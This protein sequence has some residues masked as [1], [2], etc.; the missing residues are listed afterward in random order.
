[1]NNKNLEMSY[2]LDEVVHMNTDIKTCKKLRTKYLNDLLAYAKSNTL[3][4]SRVQSCK[5]SLFPVITKQTILDNYQEFIVDADKI[6]YQQGVVHI[7]TT[8]GSTGVPFKIHQ[9]TRSRVRRV[10]SLKYGNKL[11]SFTEGEPLA[12]IRALG[13]H[14]DNITS[15]IIHN[16]D[17]NITY[18]DNA[19]LSDENIR[20]IINEFNSRKVKII[21]GYMTSLDI[22]TSY[23]VNNNLKFESYP[24]FISVGEIMLKSLRD[25]VVNDLACQ[26]I[27]QYGNEENGIIGQS[28]INSSGAEIVLNRASLI[29]EI[30]KLNEDTP[31]ES[32]EIGRVVVTDLFNYAQPMIRY[33]IGDTA[34][35]GNMKDGELLSIVDLCGRK[36]DLIRTTSGKIIDM[37]NSMPNEI[38]LSKTIKQWQ[39]IQETETRYTLI[40][41]VKEIIDIDLEVLKEKL[42]VLIGVDSQINII[43][44]DK[45]PI[46]G[47]GKRKIIVSMLNTI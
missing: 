46:L 6:P 10:A 24:T 26:I 27:T 5:L 15:G 2:H 37:Y 32:G 9:D 36:T 30:L 14:Y 22:I 7:Q 41:S 38:Y 47:S 4:Y 28:G 23:A 34:R 20:A 1:M 33:D 13:H 16:N 8:S 18:V 45:L 42:K 12:H 21:R 39:F 35:L 11:L 29:V 25:R 40:F 31:V 43:I 17:T 3:F 44:Q 19:N